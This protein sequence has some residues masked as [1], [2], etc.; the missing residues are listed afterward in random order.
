[1]DWYLPTAYDKDGQVILPRPRGD[2]VSEERYEAFVQVR[3]LRLLLVQRHD[4]HQHCSGPHWLPLDRRAVE[5]AAI[6]RLDPPFGQAL[7]CLCVECPGDEPLE[8]HR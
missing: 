5:T 6:H 8:L 4:T 3:A 2:E 1:M 7:A